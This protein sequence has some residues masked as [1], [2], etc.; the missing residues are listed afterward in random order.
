V[1]CLLAAHRRF[2]QLA[3]PFIGPCRRGIHRIPVIA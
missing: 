3:A 1:L 2:S